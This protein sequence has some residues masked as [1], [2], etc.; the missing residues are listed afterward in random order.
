MS[1]KK[2]RSKASVRHQILRITL[3][4]LTALTLTAALVFSLIT[5]FLLNERA[6]KDIILTEEFNT[7]A[8][9]GVR[10]NLSNI[11]SVVEIS[12][13]TIINS[14][15]EERIVA[16]EREY[17]VAYLNYVMNGTPLDV[18]PINTAKLKTEIY[19]EIR[20]YCDEEE[21]VFSE[22]ET[23]KVYEYACD[24]LKSALNYVPKLISD[25][26]PAAERAISILRML[27]VMELPLYLCAALCFIV[28]LAVGWK[29]HR[30]DVCFGTVAG[31]WI[32]VC[33]VLAPLA[34][35]FFYDIPSR[36]I[37]AESA[38]FY[39]VKGICDLL[40]RY[41][42]L[43]LAVILGVLTV[44]L[45][46]TSIIKAKEHRHHKHGSFRAVVNEEDGTV[47]M[48]YVAE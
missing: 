42:T 47:G 12:A 23:E 8:M 7:C 21:I 18:T 45:I 30:N 6:Y 15:T 40:F 3:D 24:S 34:I 22:E 28:N 31:S 9:A 44:L 27:S 17:T 36:L 48:K 11:G 10:E 4:V 14:V 20:A 32:G 41:S 39:L 2:K 46:V 26:L 37:L 33:T 5:H 25:R 38:L 29:R 13:D 43:L 16:Y 1:E 19:D 35:V